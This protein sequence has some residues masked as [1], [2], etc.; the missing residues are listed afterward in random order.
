MA[1]YSI[2][3]KLPVGVK[4][5]HAFNGDNFTQLFPHTKILEG[6][7]GL[8]FIDCNL[9]NCDIPE[10]AETIGCLRAQIDFCTNLHPEYRALNPNPCY[11]ECEHVIGKISVKVDG[12]SVIQDQFTYKDKVVD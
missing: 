7:K 6:V 2:L 9:V 4:D 5:G 8:R 1:N 10:D 12:R 3:K 11:Q